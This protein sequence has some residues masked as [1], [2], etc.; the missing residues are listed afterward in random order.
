MKKKNK[1]RI[2]KQV[3]M[4]VRT[5]LKSGVC[6]SDAACNP[7]LVC[8]QGVCKPSCVTRADCPPGS[9]CFDNDYCIEIF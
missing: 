7:G 9:I 1:K 6:N 4:R 8:K 2:T 5:G 3:Q